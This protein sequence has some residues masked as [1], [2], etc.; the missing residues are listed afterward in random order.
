MVHVLHLLI[1]LMNFHIGSIHV[2]NLNGPGFLMASIWLILQIVCWFCFYDRTPSTTTGPSTSN[3]S[4]KHKYTRSD[5]PLR[6][7]QQKLYHL[8]LIVNNI[9]VLKCLFYFLQ[10]LLLILIKQH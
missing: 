1:R 3:D 7:E 6:Q 5:H 8:K 9:F 10:H 4:P 2:Y